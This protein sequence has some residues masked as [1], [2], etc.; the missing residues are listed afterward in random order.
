MTLVHLAD[1]R[2][3]LARLLGTGKKKRGG[4]SADAVSNEP[5]ATAEAAPAHPSAEQKLRIRHGRQS[6]FGH[7]GTRAART[8]GLQACYQD[9]RG[10]SPAGIRPNY[11]AA[12]SRW[13]GVYAETGPD[14]GQGAERAAR[15]APKA[16]PPAWPAIGAASA[17]SQEKKRGWRREK[18]R[19]R[20]PE[21][22]KV[23]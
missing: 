6:V 23:G 10:L 12:L 9:K 22:K 20:L 21:S 2:Q 18:G 3:E 14:R 19:N 16:P 13:P 4:S 17:S 8:S 1:S 11:R 5:P 7:P 15:F